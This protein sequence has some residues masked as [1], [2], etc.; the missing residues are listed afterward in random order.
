MEAVNTYR[1][2]KFDEDFAKYNSFLDLI[3]N[4]IVDIEK[5]MFDEMSLAVPK[6]SRTDPLLFADTFYV[7]FSD[8]KNRRIRTRKTLAKG[9]LLFSVKPLA[10]SVNTKYYQQRCHYCFKKSSSLKECSMCHFTMYCQ[11]ECQRTHWTEHRLMC[12]II[13][14]SS[15]FINPKT[16]PNL[17]YIISSL[18]WKKHALDVA[19]IANG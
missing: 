6:N 1:P 2:T 13:K 17:V 9:D 7:D 3:N 18:Y 19:L 11:I 12:P 5:K 8:G 4:A 15:S 14:K 10:A 16:I